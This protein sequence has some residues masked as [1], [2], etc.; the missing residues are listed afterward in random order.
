MKRILV[1]LL[2]LGVGVALGRMFDAD[3]STAEAQQCADQNGDVNADSTRDI[4]DAIYFLEWLFNDGRG[5]EP[6][7]PTGGG[8]A[9]P[10]SGQ[11]TCY[12]ED[13]IIIDCATGSC[14]G[15]DGFYQT[16]CSAAGRFI[17]N[18]DG[19]VTDTCTGLMW[20]Q[21]TGNEGNSLTW[22]DA[23]AYCESL[24]DG[25]HDDWRL[26][27]VRELQS[28]VDY[29]L[30]DPAIDP[31]FSASSSFYWSSTSI[32]SSRDVAWFIGFDLGGIFDLKGSDGLVRAVRTAP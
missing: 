26:P 23:L 17:D 32:A 12:D 15:Q 13:G 5:P 18:G 21:D 28:I 30:F 7:C 16:G 1:L 3:T 24:E 27:N 25:S 14:A 9:L 31:V 2:A 19:T 22:C 10:D 11:T 20:Q 4:A 29:G 8:T 6:L